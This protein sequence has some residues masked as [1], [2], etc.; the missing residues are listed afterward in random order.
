MKSH[1]I[2]GMVLSSQGV[3]CRKIINSI[4]MQ[5]VAMFLVDLGHHCQIWREE[6]LILHNALL[7]ETA[8]HFISLIRTKLDFKHLYRLL[9]AFL[10]FWGFVFYRRHMKIFIP[11]IC[12]PMRKTTFTWYLDYFNQ[13]YFFYPFQIL[14]IN[15]FLPCPTVM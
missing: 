4:N 10:P 1:Q 9:I 2:K 14:L 8:S 7:Y 6:A 12:I 3:S 5:T 15:F 13:L 11:K